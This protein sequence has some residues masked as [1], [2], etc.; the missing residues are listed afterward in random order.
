MKRPHIEYFQEDVVNSLVVE[1][2]AWKVTGGYSGDTAPSIVKRSAR[3]SFGE[4]RPSAVV[5][6]GGEVVQLFS[7]NTFNVDEG[8]NHINDM[9]NIMKIETSETPVIMIDPPGMEQKDRYTLFESL[10]ENGHPAVATISDAATATY[11]YGRDKAVVVDCG[12]RSTRA[13]V[14]YDGYI[15][16]QKSKTLPFSAIH[17]TANWKRYF[18]NLGHTFSSPLKYLRRM[19]K[20]RAGKEHV[21]ETDPVKLPE[22][23]A[24]VLRSRINQ[25]ETAHEE[26]LTDYYHRTMEALGTPSTEVVP[27]MVWELPDGKS[28]TVN[29]EIRRTLGG[30]LFQSGSDS[31]AGF[32]FPEMRL[33]DFIKKTIFDCDISVRPLLCSNILLKGGVASN[34]P[35]ESRLQTELSL[36]LPQSFSVNVSSDYRSGVESKPSYASPDY[37]S[38]LG[39]SIVGSVS[40]FMPQF[41]SKSE[42]DEVGPTVVDVRVSSF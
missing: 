15:L 20:T 38:W 25:H 3:S 18:S 34:N 9:I 4:R 6:D 7:D 21:Y 2:G 37:A 42:W 5:P 26:A 22:Q 35:F 32:Q 24:E 11:S 28:I 31:A 40:S 19:E 12:H 16:R 39:G 41:I 23:E 33:Q 30:A 1:M 29:D 8:R 36:L 17:Q 10:L 14:V 27:S 13:T